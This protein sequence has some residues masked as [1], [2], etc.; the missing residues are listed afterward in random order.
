MRLVFFKEI[1]TKKTNI[2]TAG[3][4]QSINMDQDKCKKSEFADHLVVKCQIQA[5]LFTDT[6]KV[7]QKPPKLPATVTQ[8]KLFSIDW[9]A[10]KEHQ[11][12]FDPGVILFDIHMNQLKM[13]E[14]LT[15]FQL[16]HQKS[17][18]KISVWDKTAFLSNSLRQCVLSEKH[19]ILIGCH[20]FTEF[21]TDT[22]LQ[23]RHSFQ[24]QGE[25]LL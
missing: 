22:V 10:F 20:T 9:N 19:R 4:Q 1:T 5:V 3:K 14:T 16:Q 8:E 13:Q 12:S 6:L 15:S 18:N 17:A 24:F 25:A 7:I 21:S 11:M 2:S 23:P